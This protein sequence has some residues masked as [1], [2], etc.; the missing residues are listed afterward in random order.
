MDTDLREFP[1]F[2]KVLF[3]FRFGEKCEAPVNLHVLNA[4]AV[5]DICV[6]VGHMISSDFVD[7]FWARQGVKEM[8]NSNSI[9]TSALAVSTKYIPIEYQS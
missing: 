5:R 4:D 6:H 8:L 3:T 1:S 2:K 9:I 7:L